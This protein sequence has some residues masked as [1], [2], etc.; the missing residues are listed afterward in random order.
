MSAN[1]SEAAADQSPYVAMAAA[2]ARGLGVLDAAAD[3]AANPIPIE[4]D[5]EILGDAEDDGGVINEAILEDDGVA[6]HAVGDIEEESMDQAAP[7]AVP[8]APTTVVAAAP[9]VRPKESVSGRA[10][11]HAQAGPRADRGT[12][13][14]ERRLYWRS[15]SW[16]QRRLVVN[17]LTCVSFHGLPFFD[18]YPNLAATRILN[19]AGGDN[20]L[21]LRDM[22]DPAALLGDFGSSL[23]WHSPLFWSATAAVKDAIELMMSKYRGAVAWSWFDEMAMDPP[24]WPT[25]MGDSP[26]VPNQIIGEFRGRLKTWKESMKPGERDPTWTAGKGLFSS[27]GSSRYVG[28]GPEGA[29]LSLMVSCRILGRSSQA[30]CSWRVGAFGRVGGR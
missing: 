19:P 29:S 20:V 8:E 3:P 15:A 18:T 16:L 6:I 13:E 23:S 25:M 4:D 14:G 7:P 12:S 2:L 21:L 1:G 22:E 17:R 27:S 30:L 28:A 26:W 11:W 9:A 24:S 10:Q 5:D